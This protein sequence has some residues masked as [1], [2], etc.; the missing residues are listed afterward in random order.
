[1]SNSVQMMQSL[2]EMPPLVLHTGLSTEVLTHVYNLNAGKFNAVV[3]YGRKL[4]QFTLL[5]WG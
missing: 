1:M 4:S 5:V 3:K 2:E